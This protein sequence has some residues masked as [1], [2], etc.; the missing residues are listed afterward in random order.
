MNKILNGQAAQR[1]SSTGHW[2][3]RALAWVILAGT[4]ITGL[5]GCGYTLVGRASNIPEDIRQVYVEPMENGTARL[6]V[7]Q[8]LTQA[9][10]DE[11]VT[12]RRFEVINEINDADA[13][14]KGKVL[15]FAVRPL[16]FDATGLADNFEIKITADMRFQR[17]L[18]PGA[19]EGAEPEII[20]SNSRYVFRED[21]LLDS[22]AGSGFIDRENIAIEETSVRFAETL[23][24]DL[25]EGF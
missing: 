6:Q 21:Y 9:I 5:T 19:E 16:T 25:L 7:E 24:T 2:S 8:I 22:Q 4:A 20:W 14:L 23:V 18:A 10:L 3:R 11:L 12:R 15:D 1:R 17:P 13:I